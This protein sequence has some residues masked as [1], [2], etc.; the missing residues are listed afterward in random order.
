MVKY[1]SEMDTERFG[2][3]IAKLHEPKLKEFP[4][5]LKSLE[6]EKIEMAILRVDSNDLDLVHI[7][8]ENGF[9]LMDTLVRYKIEL[10]DA[11]KQTLDPRSDVRP[12]KKGESSILM[13]I[14][15]ES[16]A[17]Y[18]GHYH[19][20]P[21]LPRDKCT[22]VYIDWIRR[23]C[24]VIGVAN[25]VFVGV[26]DNKICGFSTAVITKDKIGE[27]ALAAVSEKARGFGVYSNFV[28]NLI[29]Y[30]SEQGCIAFEVDT[31][32]NNIFV[33]RA[34][35]AMGLRLFRSEYTF[36]KWFKKE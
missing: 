5:I 14:A 26:V 17:D 22:E 7:A 19:K 2:I 18:Y 20:D 34:W 6:K 28:R 32:I 8:E 9:E 36:H 25:Q 31:Q 35:V 29:T 4:K 33:Q 27:Y 11:E 1:L 23:S 24:D 16:F 3:R 12:V 13:D 10:K 21:K 30:F 15:K